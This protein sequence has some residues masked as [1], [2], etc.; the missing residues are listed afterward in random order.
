MYPKIIVFAKSALNIKFSIQLER[1]SVKRLR[2]QQVRIH[3]PENK[4]RTSQL[5]SVGD[6]N[7]LETSVIRHRVVYARGREGGGLLIPWTHE[8]RAQP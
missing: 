7:R 4:K 5:G 1:Q 3:R 6:T 8:E 2:E